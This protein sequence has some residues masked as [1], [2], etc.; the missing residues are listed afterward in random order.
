MAMR[1]IGR[2]CDS[3]NLPPPCGY[4]MHTSDSHDS[5]SLLAEKNMESFQHLECPQALL[6]DVCMGPAKALIFLVSN[7]IRE[8]RSPCG[9]VGEP[10]ARKRKGEPGGGSGPKIGQYLDEIRSWPDRSPHPAFFARARSEGR[11][12]HPPSLFELRRTR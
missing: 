1:F 11:P 6:R 10:L 4:G 2:P 7:R 3:Q 5:Q 8:S 9:E 12:P